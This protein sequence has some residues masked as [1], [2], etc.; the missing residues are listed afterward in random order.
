MTKPERPRFS[1]WRRLP[2][3]FRSGEHAPI[4]SGKDLARIIL[5]LPEGILDQA[6]LLG[7]KV[8]IPA[9]QEYCE[10][11]LKRAVEFESVRQKVTEFEVRRGPL[12][13]LAEIADDLD[14]LAEWKESQSDRPNANPAREH[15]PNVEQPLG[16]P[17][18]SPARILPIEVDLVL[19]DEEMHDRSLQ[20]TADDESTAGG[21]RTEVDDGN[22]PT[23]TPPVG[24]VLQGPSSQ[25]VVVLN[26]YSPV[27][28]VIR[29]ASGDGDEW[30][31]L[32]CLRRGVPVPA[33][34]ASE[35]IRALHELEQ[36]HRDE[37]ALERPLVHALHR[38]ALE[39]QVLLTDAWPGRFDSRM[40]TAIRNVQESVERILSGK[41][42]RYDSLAPRPAPERPL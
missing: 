12:E 4:R 10:Y 22:E 31:F 9:L 40:I 38:L 37:P 1:R 25:S 32:P 7:E 21:D 30:A 28:V 26:E 2:P 6:E 14:Y 23:V 5:Y 16:P 8:G 3:V 24:F 41:D 11:L 18:D 17:L 35:L 42:I 20:I 19:S 15:A 27:E 13:G 29:H 33:A 36:H 39:S 34:R